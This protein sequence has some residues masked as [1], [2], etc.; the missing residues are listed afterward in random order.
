MLIL[1]VLPVKKR[2]VDEYLMMRSWVGAAVAQVTTTV[3]SWCQGQRSDN[4]EQQTDVQPPSNNGQSQQNPAQRQQNMDKCEIDDDYIEDD[5]Q[6]QELL[7]QNNYALEEDNTDYSMCN[8]E[9]DDNDSR[10]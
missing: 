10:F 1:A 2:S 4:A 5:N 6:L 8:E 7:N 9:F 3:V